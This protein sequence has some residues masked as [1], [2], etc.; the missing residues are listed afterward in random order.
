M[1]W[2]EHIHQDPAI[3]CGKP[4]IKGTRMSVEMV[5]E[6]LG[7]GWSVDALAGEY[8]VTPEQIRAAQA[9]AAAWMRMDHPTLRTG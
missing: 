2:R 1:D 6:L 5:L 4:C 7:N 9:F 3:L 8:A